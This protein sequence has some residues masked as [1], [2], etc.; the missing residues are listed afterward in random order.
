VHSNIALQCEW[1]ILVEAFRPERRWFLLLLVDVEKKTTKD[2]LSS[3]GLSVALVAH[4]AC[5]LLL[6]LLPPSVKSRST[7]PHVS[8]SFVLCVFGGSPLS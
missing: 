5:Q 2:S 3:D 7:N 4:C 6:L 8:K 1:S